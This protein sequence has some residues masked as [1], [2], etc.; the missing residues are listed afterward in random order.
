MPTNPTFTPIEKRSLAQAV[1]E[2]LIAF[3]RS[4]QIRPGEALPPQSELARQLSVSRPV[5]REALQ[6]LASIGMIE[7]RPGS[8]CY[9]RDPNPPADTEVIADVFTHENALEVLE[10]RMVIEV[11]LAG[12]AA[13]R[14]N[15]RDFASMDRHLDRLKHAIARNRPTSQITSDFHQA[16]AQAGHN[17]VLLRMARLLMQGR[18]AQGLRIEHALPDISRR[19]H[20]SHL[21]LALA[22]RG[23][24]EA[25]ARAAM[26][27][28]LQTAHGWEEHVDRLRREIAV[29]DRGDAWVAEALVP[30]DDKR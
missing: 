27:E 20:D 29:V 14:A 3:I 19:E 4:G 11:E 13:L 5:L 23:G 24:D 12:F 2:R 16:L 25:L 6:G 26:R 18:L 1:I 8:G 7:I 17:L 9:L 28:H 10:A 30:F 22:V 21:R 15:E